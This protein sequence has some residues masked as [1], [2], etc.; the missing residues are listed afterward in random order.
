MPDLQGAM[1]ETLRRYPVAGGHRAR[2]ARPL[3]LADYCLEQGL[4]VEIAMTV[5]HFLEELFPNLMQFD[6]DRFRPPRNE[7]RKAGAYT[8]FGLGDYT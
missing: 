6:L 4:D 1:M 7:H 3:T 5:P 8:P 2:V